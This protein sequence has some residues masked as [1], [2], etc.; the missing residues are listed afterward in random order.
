MGS[1]EE[2][3]ACSTAGLSWVL[4]G[5]EGW[6]V[7]REGVHVLWGDSASSGPVPHHTYQVHRA[8]SERT[9]AG[10]RLDRWAGAHVCRAKERRGDRLGSQGSR[11]VIRIKAVVEVTE[12]R[13]RHFPICST[14]VTLWDI[15]QMST[16]TAGSTT[17]TGG[18]RARWR[19]G[20][21]LASEG[22]G[23]RVVFT[24]LS[25]HPPGALPSAT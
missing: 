18:S 7:G 21:S 4:R 6:Q 9:V 11:Q 22:G 16:S 17:Q 24:A 1:S 5:E 19:W 15:T 13:G 2:G 10:T 3:N 8:H 12:D 25:L 20:G 14:W 23:Y